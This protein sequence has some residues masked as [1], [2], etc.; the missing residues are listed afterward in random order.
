MRTNPE[1]RREGAREK[2]GDGERVVMR[3]S[4]R[5]EEKGRGGEGEREI[6]RE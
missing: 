4:R 3:E 5:D 2:G 1:G 6:G